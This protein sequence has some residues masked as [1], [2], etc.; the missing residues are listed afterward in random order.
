[1]GSMNTQS[2]KSPTNTDISWGQ[3]LSTCFTFIIFTEHMLHNVCEV[4]VISENLNLYSLQHN[5][6]LIS[7]WN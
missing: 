5:S 3:T 4:V 1:M 6:F 7:A 2:I